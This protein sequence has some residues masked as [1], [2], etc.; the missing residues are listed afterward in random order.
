M[1]SI[2]LV[3][4]L[5]LGGFAAAQMPGQPTEKLEVLPLEEIR[6]QVEAARDVVA[7]KLPSEESRARVVAK[8]NG[9][10]MTVAAVLREVL[11]RFGAPL[12]PQLLNQNVMNMEAEKRGTKIDEKD[13]LLAVQLYLGQK[14]S[15]QSKQTLRE[16]LV[17][18]GLGW[19]AFEKLMSDKAKVE[20]IVRGDLGIP[21]KA[22][23][24]P[25]NPFILQIWAGQKLRG[26][27]T[28]ELDEKKL[29]EG[30]AGKV[31][32]TR[33]ASS[34]IA[35]LPSGY[36]AF[37]VE[38]E[39]DKQRIIVK[40]AG[41]RWPMYTVPNIEIQRLTEEGTRKPATV[42]DAFN[43]ALKKAGDV[44]RFV[45]ISPAEGG[46]SKITAPVVTAA[47]KFM[48]QQTVQ[49]ANGQPEV[50]MVEGKGEAPLPEVVDAIANK[51]FVVKDGVASPKDADHPNYT[52][53]ADVKAEVDGKDVPL[54]EALAALTG[55]PSVAIIQFRFN[56]FELPD[57]PVPMEMM[58]DRE[59]LLSYVIGRLEDIHFEEAIKSLSKFM[60]A[61]S[62]LT[63]KGFPIDEAEV[64]KVIQAE[65][66]KFNNPIFNRAMILQ[67]Q[68][69]TE[70]EE[71]RRIWVGN[72]VDKAIGTDISDEALKAYWEKHILWF[73]NATVEASHILV[74]KLNPE[75]GKEDWEYAE[76][77]IDKIAM[78]LFAGGNPAQR[79]AALAKKYSDDKGSASQGGKL[80]E[81]GY[82]GQMVK[83]FS[84]AAF[85]LR[86]NEVS[87]PVKTV[88]GFHLI[89]C[90]KKK[91][92]DREKNSLD[93]KAALER[94]KNAFQQERRDKWL[95]ENV[96]KGL[97]IERL[98]PVLNKP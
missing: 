93:N 22:T 73:G 78:E 90:H 13:F 43:A 82:K 18:S 65:K 75:T 11:D 20:K 45:T 35:G 94:V 47:K 62:V 76:N 81:F 2:V 84:E 46:G 97:E 53:P 6:K 60:R 27:Y 19:D 24:E 1:R 66:A 79:F 36:Y 3:W 15:I 49:G 34:L 69:K 26:K 52:L 23:P 57:L 10:D 74:D 92:P 54:V 55:K 38:G 32:T 85:A 86:P 91:A 14:K 12:V 89:L 41:R 67:A 96:Y 17:E 64:R 51:G 56:D 88:H 80:P 5:M 59:T 33:D 61:K 31:G 72:G 7:A 16:I 21:R 44:K 48:H 58:L 50:K 39:G 8:V 30:V 63:A 40:P 77:R 95:E 29:P 68:G 70:F 9:D 98:G 42:L 25:L 4:A 37:T 87:A 71:D 83:E 28:M